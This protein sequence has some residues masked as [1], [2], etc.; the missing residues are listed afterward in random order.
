MVTLQFLHF[1]PLL[2][3]NISRKTVEALFEYYVVY[4]NDSLVWT[5]KLW[6]LEGKNEIE[7]VVNI[8]AI[9]NCLPQAWKS[10]THFFKL[11]T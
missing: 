3:E 10:E 11:H 4:N 6:Q 9:V 5:A 1:F 7:E 8:I 2:S